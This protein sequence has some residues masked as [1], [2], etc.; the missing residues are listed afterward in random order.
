MC[1]Y[2]W[3]RWTLQFLH[4][5]RDVSRDSSLLCPWEVSIIMWSAHLT[6]D[7]PG[8][9]SPSHHID[10]ITCKFTS[11]I[12]YWY[13]STIVPLSTCYIRRRLRKDIPKGGSRLD[14][15]NDLL[16]VP[17]LQAVTTNKYSNHTRLPREA[18][19]SFNGTVHVFITVE[20][21]HM[22]NL[23]RQ[24]SQIYMFCNSWR[25]FVSIF[26]SMLTGSRGNLRGGFLWFMQ[27]LTM[28]P[29]S[30]LLLGVL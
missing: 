18:Y 26:S 3:S 22:I 17:V 8:V 11:H 23:R 4:H 25:V 27:L 28:S 13:T 20:L 15:D 1:R 29:Q 16:T 6:E 5:D 24:L 2:G 21:W 30:Q 19:A 9:C 12:W 7:P 14:V 10:F